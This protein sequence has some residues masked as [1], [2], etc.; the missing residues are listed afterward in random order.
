M[1]LLPATPDRKALRIELALITVLIAAV[2]ISIPL[3]LGRIGLSWD[4]LNHHIYL[5]WIAESGRFD[6]DYMAAGGQAAQYPYLYWP[7]YKLA[8][9]GASGIQAGVVLALLHVLAVPPV[10]LVARSLLPGCGWGAAA[11]RA[12]AV[13][14]GFMSAVPLKTLESTG[15]DFLA[16]IPVLW[17]IALSLQC[18]TGE[19]GAKRAT[20]AGILAGAATSAKFTNGPLVALLPILFLF[21]GIPVAQR[22]RMAALL[23]G[24]EVF[25]FAATYAVW[26]WHMWVVFGNPV[27]P[28][29][30]SVFEPL[31]HSLGWKP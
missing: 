15:N 31:R 30:E 8:I 21:P 7:V 24:G 17:A 22:I 3:S 9:S 12:C 18:V 26:G 16:A 20:C 19:G 14:L 10:W 1:L 13:L 25:S 5:G 4:S 6:L 11:S 23:I 28:F 27:F 2:F 29:G